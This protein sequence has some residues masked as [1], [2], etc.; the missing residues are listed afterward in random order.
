MS[1]S[2]FVPAMFRNTFASASVTRSCVAAGIYRAPGFGRRFGLA[3]VTGAAIG[4]RT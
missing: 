3:F 2:L 1:P 4:L